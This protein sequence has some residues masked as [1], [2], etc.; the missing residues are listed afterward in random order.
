MMFENPLHFILQMLSL[1]LHPPHGPRTFKLHDTSMPA[2]DLF[3]VFPVLM[4]RV[5]YISASILPSLCLVF[6][7]ARGEF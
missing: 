5:Y 3:T 1:M 2:I 7:G 4:I 6:R